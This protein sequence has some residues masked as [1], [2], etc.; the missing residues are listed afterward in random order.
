MNISLLLSRARNGDKEALEQMAPLVRNELRRIAR[1]RLSAEPH[2]HTLQ[3]TALINEAYIRL[4]EG[5]EPEW[6]NRT[7]FFSLASRLM[8]Q[9]LTDHAREA[10]KSERKFVT[11]DFASGG[12][13]RT[14]AAVVAL[15]AAIEALERADQRKS[16]VI[17]LRYF[18]GLEIEE[19]G[20][21]LGVSAATVRRDLRLAEA[22]LRREIGKPAGQTA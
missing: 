10:G 19:I 22:W 21:A 7:H 20:P 3:P 9:I 4:L 16:S 17:D 5:A 15:N 6:V 8:R 2:D 18:G 13:A 12:S 14:P 1:H 11:L